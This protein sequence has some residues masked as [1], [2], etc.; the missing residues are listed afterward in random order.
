MQRDEKTRGEGP[1]RFWIFKTLSLSPS[2]QDLE[3][4]SLRLEMQ[5]RQGEDELCL[6]L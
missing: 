2:P 4:T 3:L 1:P 6:R 5:V